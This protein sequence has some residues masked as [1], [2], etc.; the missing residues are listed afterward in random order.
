MNDYEYHDRLPDPIERMEANIERMMD[1]LDVSGDPYNLQFTCP[2]C[3]KRAKF[4]DAQTLDERPDSMIWCS[5][6]FWD[7]MDVMK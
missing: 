2:N 4:S 3:K 5:E 6:C 7:M 1:E